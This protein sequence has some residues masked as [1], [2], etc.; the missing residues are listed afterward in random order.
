[1]KLF[2]IDSVKKLNRIKKKNRFMCTSFKISLSSAIIEKILLIF[3]LIFSYYITF[4][5]GERGFF[6]FDQSIVFDGGFRI[7]SGQIPYK[8]FLIP[9]GPIVFCIQAVFFKIF[10]VN[11]FAYIFAAAFINLLATFLSYWLITI[12]YPDRRYFG[13]ISGLLTAVWFYPP[14]GTPWP[15][16]TSFF[17]FL[18][19]LF[20]IIYAILKE[21][22]PK[23]RLLIIFCSGVLIFLAFCSKQNVG[24]LILPLFVTLIIYNYRQNLRSLSS[25]LYSFLTGFL[26]GIIGFLLW[27]KNFSDMNNFIYYFLK[28]PANLGIKRLLTN[29]YYF[30]QEFKQEGLLSWR[31]GFF[32]VLVVLA[33]FI[34]S[35][36]LKSSQRKEQNKN[37]IIANIIS[38][39][40]I[41]FQIFFIYLTFNQPENGL[42]FNGII[43]VVIFD[44][45][46]KQ[47][48]R[49]NIWGV[50]AKI[51]KIALLGGIGL[52]LVILGINVSLSRRVHDIFKDSRFPHYFNNIEQLK[53]LKWG[54]PTIID[55]VEVKES[56][57]VNLYRYLQAEN[58]HF[59]IF[60]DFTI[61]YGLL[62]M[63]S[64]QPIL[65]FHK[66]ITYPE[67]YNSQLDNWLV[68]ALESSHIEI[69]VLEEKSRINTKTRFNDF[70]Q[71]RNYI[72]Q[73]Y[74]LIKKLRIFMIYLKSE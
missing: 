24:L 52:C 3:L 60:P 15:D 45:I 29:W 22:N 66:G 7:F 5:A 56:D 73:N 25:S 58:R 55:G 20:F 68:Q 64:P 12:L 49:K 43:F 33:F 71:L 72:F 54:N 4:K 38:L 28:L 36:L 51:L 40:L 35:R 26:A 18:S 19:G 8:D 50:E 67:I 17:F 23:L 53:N 74:R 48:I 57:I 41:F 16:Q 70:P 31:V 32:V 61:F 27:I 6:A 65:W 2:V 30:L 1:V 10:G 46:L 39:Y 47:L 11:Y 37:L 69:V 21:L 9:F 62:N 13:L 59:F 44:F 14:F 42:S 63:P 34:F